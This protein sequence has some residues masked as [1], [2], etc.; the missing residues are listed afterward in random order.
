MRNSV[1]EVDPKRYGRLLARK[2]PAV[3]RTEEENERLI[4]ELETLDRR[5]AD[6]SPE[7]REYSELLTVLIEAFE[8]NH[9][10]LEG[11]TP[12]SR[13]RSLMEEH[14]LRQRDLLDVFGSRGIASEVVSGKRAISKTQAKS[15]ARIFRVPAD[16][17]L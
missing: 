4:A 17:F 11:S 15:L 16:L 5:H 7:E 9:Y 1:L 10:T 14:G 6:L 2:L 3:I 13:L 8:D 12:D